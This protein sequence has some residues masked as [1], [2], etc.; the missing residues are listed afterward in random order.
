M[1]FVHGTS[2][3]ITV[4]S[5]P[6]GAHVRIGGQTGTTPVTLDV[7]KGKNYSIEATLGDQHRYV[8]LQRNIEPVTLVNLVFLPGFIVDACTGAL[9]NYDPDFYTINFT[10]A[11]SVLTSDQNT[12]GK[13]WK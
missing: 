5:N 1:T 8:P 4:H 2:Q 13:H 6:P 10:D 12:S 7:P 3:P 11:H 9:M